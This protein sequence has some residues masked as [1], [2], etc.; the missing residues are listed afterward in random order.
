MSRDREGGT[1]IEMVFA[2]RAVVC[3]AIAD[4]IRDP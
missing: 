3:S 2:E 4:D 1:A